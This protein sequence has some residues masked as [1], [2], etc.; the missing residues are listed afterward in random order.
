MVPVGGTDGPDYQKIFFSQYQIIN[1]GYIVGHMAG[2]TE[3]DIV[4]STQLLHK[5]VGQSLG[6]GMVLSHK[7][8]LV[9]AS[10]V[11]SAEEVTEAIAQEYC[12][13]LVASANE[14]KILMDT[15]NFIEKTENLKKI[16]MVVTPNELPEVGLINW[17]E[18]LGKNI[19]LAF[20]IDFTSGIISVSP[21]GSL[22]KHHFGKA[23]P[24]TKISVVDSSGNLLPIRKEG[25]LV[26][27]GFN[28]AHGCSE[29]VPSHKNP[30]K[31]GALHT[32]LGCRM[33]PGGDIFLL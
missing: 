31:N 28:V 12:T 9:V 15:P 24:H 16:I 21:G 27:E 19:T 10:E 33:E 30:I 6:L 11:F 18:R 29:T 13:T 2:I 32:S 8:K 17:L 7:A 3:E 14:I 20:G 5:P 25:T 22:N 26:I 1:T 23:I 4:L